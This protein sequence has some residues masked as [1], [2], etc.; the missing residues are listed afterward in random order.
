MSEPIFSDRDS[1]VWN[2]DDDKGGIAFV[3]GYVL[4]V[5]H[6]PRESMWGWYVNP[7]NPTIEGISGKVSDDH[8]DPRSKAKAE[9]VKHCP[10]AV[11][12]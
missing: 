7:M 6:F 2:N 12:E 1:V 9:A 4:M 3:D 10:L 5:Q 8:P 11:S